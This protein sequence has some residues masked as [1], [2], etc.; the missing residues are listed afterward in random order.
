MIVNQQVQNIPVFQSA[1]D[2][3]QKKKSIIH[4]SKSSSANGT[5]GSSVFVLSV[6]VL[7]SL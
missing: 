2:T 5:K 1:K 6:S 7:L 4:M 3:R